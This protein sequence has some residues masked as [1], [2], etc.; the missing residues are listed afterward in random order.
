VDASPCAYVR[1]ARCIVASRTG[2]H[3][4]AG[5]T[6][7]PAAVL[8]PA[9]AFVRSSLSSQRSGGTIGACT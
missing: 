8:S 7:P 9:M 1:T 4:L 2:A 5:D 3:V 6:T